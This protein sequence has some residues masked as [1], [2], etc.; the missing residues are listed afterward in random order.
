M[1]D[2]KQTSVGTATPSQPVDL[3]DYLTKIAASVPGTIYAFRLRPDGTVSMPYAAPTL[4][5]VCG[6]DPADLAANAAPLFAL[7]PEA[8]RAAVEHSMRISAQH[9]TMWEQQFRINHPQKGEVWIA[10]SSRPEREPDGSTL[11]HGFGRDVTG[12]RRDDEER[13]LAAAVFS[14][15]QEGV[16]ITDPDGR[17]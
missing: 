13:R 17:I 8:D 12:S 3:Q 2:P 15:T 14:N 9:L 11:W 10:A 4:A 16:V 6:I 1:A 5:D 7:M